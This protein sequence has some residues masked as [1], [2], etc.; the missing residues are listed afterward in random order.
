MN[1]RQ[2]RNRISYTKLR[3]LLKETRDELVQLHSY[4][5]KDCGGGCPAEDI[6][7]R[8]D[9]VLRGRKEPE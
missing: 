8:V 7:R 4:Y 9:A 3:D 1:R 2:S 6:I 5:Y